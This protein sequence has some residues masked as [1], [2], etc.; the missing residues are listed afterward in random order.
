M[1]GDFHEEIKGVGDRFDFCKQHISD[2][3]R[4]RREEDIAKSQ[5]HIVND[6]SICNHC[7]TPREK[8]FYYRGE[9]FNAICACDCQKEKREKEA[10]QKEREEQ[11]ESA[12]KNVLKLRE[13]GILDVKYLKYRFDNDDSQE[14]NQSKIARAYVK[15]WASMKKNGL[16]LLFY[17]NVGAG[18]SFYAGCIVNAM[19]DRGTPCV[20]TNTITMIDKLSA[21]NFDGNKVRIVRELIEKNDLIVIDDIGAEHQSSYRLEVLFNLLDSIY[22]SGKPM[23]ITSNLSPSQLQSPQ[24]MDLE[25]IYD[26]ILERCQP[27]KFDQPSRRKNRLKTD[28][29]EMEQILGVKLS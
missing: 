26:R 18:K 6:L 16:G 28:R 1:S 7:N 8:K 21:H 23:I 5:V 14:S 27:V 2:M 19:I 24:N 29:M 25:R 11:R 4:K 17:G 20:M 3:C 12:R 22:R 15:E 9:A 10:A 13:Q